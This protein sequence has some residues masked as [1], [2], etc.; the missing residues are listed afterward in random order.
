MKKLILGCVVLGLASVFAATRPLTIGRSAC[1][2]NVAPDCS[3]AGYRFCAEGGVDIL[4]IPVAMTKDGVL[5]TLGTP[6]LD[7]YGLKGLIT[8]YTW[9]EVKASCRLPA[10]DGFANEPLVRLE[11]ALAIGAKMKGVMLDFVWTY[12]EAAADKAVAAAKAAGIRPGNILLLAN[13]EQ[14]LAH[15]RTA[16]PDCRV[17]GNYGVNV[18]AGKWSMGNDWSFKHEDRMVVYTNMLAAAKRA[19]VQALHLWHTCDS[20]EVALAHGAGFKVFVSK[21]STREQAQKLR[22]AGV[23]AWGARCPHSVCDPDWIVKENAPDIRVYGRPLAGEKTADGK[24]TTVSFPVDGRMRGIALMPGSTGTLASV[25]LACADGTRTGWSMRAV[26]ETVTLPA[27]ACGKK[28]GDKLFLPDMKLEIPYGTPIYGRPMMGGF[29][30]RSGSGKSGVEL[31]ERWDTLPGAS[32]RW[33]CFDI[34]RD[35]RGGSDLYLNGE[36]LMRLGTGERAWNWRLD[37][38]PLNATGHAAV[39]NM[40]VTLPAGWKYRIVEDESPATDGRFVFCDFAKKPCAKRFFGG[41]LKGLVAGFADFGGVP[42]KVASPD[43]AG[44]VAIARI[45]QGQHSLECNSWMNRSPMWGY[46]AEV[47]FRVPSADYVRAHILFALDPDPSKKKVLTVR[48]AHYLQNSGGSGGRMIADTVVEC[49]AKTGLPAGAERVGAVV[50][51]GVTCGVYRLVVPIDMGSLIDVADE[52]D[53]LDLDFLG[54]TVS[55]MKKGTADSSVPDNGVKSAFTI[56][57]AT[58]EQTPFKVAFAQKSPGNVFTADEPESAHETGFDLVCVTPCSGTV[59]WTAK[60]D[61]GR[62]VFDGS[63]AFTL[64]AKGETAHV[65]IPLGKAD[66]VGLYGLEVAFEGGC[67]GAQPSRITHQARFCVTPEAG[68]RTPPEKSPFGAGAFYAHSVPTDMKTILPLY[69]KMGIRRISEWPWTKNRPDAPK[70]GD[71]Y[72]SSGQVPILSPYR[73]KFDPKTGTFGIGE[74]AVIKDLQEKIRKLPYVDTVLVWHESAPNAEGVAGP[75]GP[76]AEV[77][78]LPPPAATEKGIAAAKYLAACERIVRGHFPNLKMQIGNS[79]SSLGAATVPFRG[80]ASGSCYDLLGTENPGQEVMPERAG[81]LNSI[82]WVRKIAEGS[83][84]RPIAVA[85]CH[86][87]TSRTSRELGEPTQAAYY[88]RDVLICLASRMPFINPSTLIE[89]R[90]AYYHTFWGASGLCTRGPT[91]YPKLAYLSYAVL[92]KVLDG[93]TFSRQ[94]DTGSPTVYAVEF[95]RDDGKYVTALWCARGEAVCKTGW[96]AVKEA[97]SMRGRKLSTGKTPF[98]QEP[99]YIVT[100]KPLDGFE[101]VDR[102]FAKGEKLYDGGRNAI[103]L[104]TA[105]LDFSPT[106]AIVT[107]LTKCAPVFVPGAFSLGDVKDP[108]AGACLE[109]RLDTSVT[110]YTGKVFCENVKLV[111]KTPQPLKPDATVIGVKLK[112]D[113]N[114]GQVYFTVEDAKGNT[115]GSYRHWTDAFMSDWP[116]N[117]CVNFDGWGYV[118]LS[119]RDNDLVFDT[120]S[121]DWKREWPGMTCPVPPF[122]LKAITVSRYRHPY[123]LFGYLAP[124]VNPTLRLH[125]VF[126]Y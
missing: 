11:D 62:K 117:T 17:I 125:S 109:L 90:N 60:D 15:L 71:G 1:E 20:N 122:K 100:E 33:Y 110:Q 113:S 92:T 61:A 86:E 5:V 37:L 99:S 102:G 49:D 22:A 85:A 29:W 108:E 111:L 25:S 73:S 48:L 121:E 55:Q 67:A 59:R 103:R 4:S 119:L 51:D 26:G 16:H 126:A 63:A 74:E 50:K 56:F 65:A 34:G 40:T 95:K 6:V 41:T 116:G 14:N 81:G 89:A 84:K 107:P 38:G 39:T 78:G 44:D 64:R 8:G 83:A 58:L 7:A 80:G 28:R 91:C 79:G 42:V 12:R 87:F 114:W 21:V 88:M 112:G 124:Y 13:G 115:Y 66:E 36:M 82:Q 118:Y 77:L 96:F 69:D 30:T 72:I 76:C 93:A 27:D 120:P 18:T 47:R 105:A 123:G 35:L 3:L 104:S 19:N 10:V 45:N 2:E 57:G 9:A 98:G 23:D 53:Y 106:N 52:M 32:R 24:K 94:L 31:V 46:P 75:Y 43:D 97:Y 70:K 68:R 54:R 101:I